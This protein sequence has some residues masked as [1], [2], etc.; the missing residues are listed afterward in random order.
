MRSPARYMAFSV[1]LLLAGCS[2]S[3]G[4]EEQEFADFGRTVAV[5]HPVGAYEYEFRRGSEADVYY[6]L[7]EVERSEP[8][9]VDFTLVVE[10]PALGRNFGFGGL[11]VACEVQGEITEA[12]TDAR[13]GEAFD[14]LY[15]FP[16]R[17][18]VPEGAVFLIVTVNHHDQTVEFAGEI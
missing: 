10:V 2:T 8:G 12:E 18:A 5:P 7:E 1:A 11:E 9:R 15:E 16:M 6:R 14:G 13:L 4:L 17:C 3:D